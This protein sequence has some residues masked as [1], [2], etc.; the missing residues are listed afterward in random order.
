MMQHFYH[1]EERD[2]FRVTARIR[3]TI[4]NMAPTARTVETPFHTR[5]IFWKFPRPY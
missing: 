1:T 3:V 5:G 4:G 2:A